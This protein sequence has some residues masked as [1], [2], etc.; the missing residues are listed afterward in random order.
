[1]EEKVIRIY[2]DKIL[3]FDFDSL[4]DLFAATSL[5]FTDEESGESRYVEPEEIFWADKFQYYR[6]VWKQT[7]ERL[8][9]KYLPDVDYTFS[10]QIEIT[11]YTL[12]L[13]NLIS[14]PRKYQQ[15]FKAELERKGF[16]ETDM[17]DDLKF[18]LKHLKVDTLLTSENLLRILSKD[19]LERHFQIIRLMNFPPL[20]EL[21]VFYDLVYHRYTKG[22]SALHEVFSSG[23]IHFPIH[24]VLE[25]FHK[26]DFS[27]SHAL[28]SKYGMDY[29]ENAPSLV[30][31]KDDFAAIRL[32]SKAEEGRH[33]GNYVCPCCATENESSV[34]LD[35]I[36]FLMVLEHMPLKRE[37]GFLLFDE[38]LEEYK[39]GIAEKFYDLFNNLNPDGE[40]DLYIMVEGASEE[41]GLPLLAIKRKMFLHGRRI[42]VYNCESKEKLLSDFKAFRKKQKNLKMICLLD[43][44]ARKEKE[45]ISRMIKDQKNKYGLV[46]IEKGTWEDLFPLSQSVE[47]LNKM[48]PDGETIVESDFPLI[49]EFPREVGKILHEKKKASFDK[50]KFSQHICLSLDLVQIPAPI[51]MLFDLADKLLPE[52]QSIFSSA[53]K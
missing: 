18:S 24:A 6:E 31:F 38:V 12:T 50:V 11:P 46:Y 28:F 43:S 29:F 42:K 9:K 15:I 53:A 49:K 2:I 47:V 23:Q 3:G 33:T 36:E 16:K 20:E 22:L 45:E 5:S 13:I 19:E 35:V 44:D 25:P 27:I 7:L 39:K 34:P 40:S 52:N 30:Q 48:Y 1:M 26:S 17:L 4:L 32:R 8:Y 37:I 21:D 14:L 51:V 10:W 41:I